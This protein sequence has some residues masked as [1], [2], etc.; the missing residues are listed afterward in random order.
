M[1]DSWRP[2]VSH[3]APRALALL[4]AVYC[5]SRIVAYEETTPPQLSAV[6]AL[7]LV[8]LWAVWAVAAVLL[9]LGGLVPPQAG[10]T[11]KRLARGMRQWGMTIS[12]SLLAMWAAAFLIT[13]VNRGWVSAGNYLMLAL[14]AGWAG[15]V[16]SRDLADVR[17]VREEEGADA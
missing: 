15:W 14:F 1:C 13:D 11:S 12:L 17:A 8:P 4:W 2:W 3:A 9:A 6:A 10:N 5:A 16:A 7:L